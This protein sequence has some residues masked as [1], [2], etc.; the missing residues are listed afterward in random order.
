MPLLLQSLILPWANVLV[1]IVAAVENESMNEA[2][3]VTIGNS[4]EA[5]AP[6][7]TNV[8]TSH[9]IL[10]S[11]PSTIMNETST[12]TAGKVVLLYTPS[13]NMNETKTTSGPSTNMSETKATSGPSTD[14]NKTKTTA[15]H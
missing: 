10:P 9:P 1:L 11:S 5:T 12:V 15:V 6:N 3:T 14:M 13:T 7:T 4:V 2:T 8:T